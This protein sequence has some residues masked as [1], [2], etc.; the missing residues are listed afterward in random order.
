[1]ALN[2]DKTCLFAVIFTHIHQIRP[3]LQMP[4]SETILDLVLET[5]LL[6]YWFTHDMKTHRHLKYILEISYKRIWVIRKLKKSGV[7]NEDKLG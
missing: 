7:S 2:T 3:L 6:G 5:N 4:G 1:M